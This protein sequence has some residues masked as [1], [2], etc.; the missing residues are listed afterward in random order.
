MSSLRQCWGGLAAGS[1]SQG[2]RCGGRPPTL[3]PE[4]FSFLVCLGVPPPVCG[5]LL[6]QDPSLGPLRNPHS[7]S[8]ALVNLC[9]SSH[10]L[11]S[12]FLLGQRRAG[13]A[14]VLAQLPQ[15]LL[16]GPYL[17]PL[18]AF[19]EV[20]VL[21]FLLPLGLFPAMSP[22]LGNVVQETWISRDTPSPGHL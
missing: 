6:R 14:E 3:V 21:L 10:S 12:G 18:L 2:D 19:P 22:G 20:K 11:L 17:S 8:Q 15:H 4:L 13:G 9:S 5:P 1:G 7:S 16:A